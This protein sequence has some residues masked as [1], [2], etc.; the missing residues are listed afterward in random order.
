MFQ[1]VY[2]FLMVLFCN[3]FFYVWFQFEI[4]FA[5]FSKHTGKLIAIQICKQIPPRWN[6]SPAMKRISGF[7]KRIPKDFKIP[8][9]NNI[10]RLGISFLNKE[11]L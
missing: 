2:H 4:G 11:Q 6:L 9:L 1:I 7:Q 10:G 3:S 5:I 8:H